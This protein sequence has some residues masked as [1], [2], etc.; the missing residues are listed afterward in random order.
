MLG[1]GLHGLGLAIVL[2]AAGIGYGLVLRPLDARIDDLDGLSLKL[3]AALE[4]A[5][6]VRAKHERLRLDMAA[7]EAG[8]AGL[9]NR[10]PDEPLEAE[11][12]SQAAQAA[13]QSGL[14][15]GD[16]RPGVV[17]TSRQCS[18]MEIQLACQGSYR[19]ICDFL[20]RLAALP[21]L[22]QVEKLEIG[23]AGPD[24]YPVTLWLVV[25]F[26][27]TKAPADPGAKGGQAHG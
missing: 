27:L 2:A 23:A 13:S 12:L 7:M 3:Q 24:G 8:A 18:Q 9:E 14:Q 4:D 26:R 17:R 10:V 20:D 6:T 5:P 15:I 21:R 22:S 11:F 19:S 16:Y 1:V 25:Y